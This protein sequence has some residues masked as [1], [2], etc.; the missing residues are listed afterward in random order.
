MKAFDYADG[1]VVLGS[2]RPEVYATCS[3][4]CVAERAGQIGS[5]VGHHAPWGAV[6]G[7]HVRQ[8]Y[9]EHLLGAGI[10]M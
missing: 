8:K 7:D 6:S 9:I 5:V 1:L 3:E 4:D 2:G 10:F